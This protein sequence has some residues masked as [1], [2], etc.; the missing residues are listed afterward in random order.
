M[1]AAVTFQTGF[2]NCFKVGLAMVVWVGLSMRADAA[3]EPVTK[4]VELFNGKNLE[5]FYTWLVDT[6][7]TDPRRVFSV[8]NG[9]LRISGDG[10]GYLSTTR[11]YRDYRLELEFKWGTVNTAWGDRLGKARDSGLFLHSAGPDGNSHDGQG[12]FKAAIEC[13][14]FQGATG[15]ILLIRGT[16]EEGRL[17]APRITA[18]VASQPDADGWPVWKPDGEQ[19]IMERWGR[20]NWFGKD[21]DWKDLLDF[22]GPNDIEKARGEWNKLEC[23]CD[24]GRIT[25]KLNGTIVNEA[26]DVFP[27]GGPILLQCEGS[28]I[29]FRNF[30]L[31]PLR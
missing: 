19:R 2:M 17:I 26:F 18:R 4:R 20:L 11:A 13:N 30:E 16:G 12:A 27:S 23:L 15:D 1:H 25:I 9:L 8:T 3:G 29:F 24:G 28:E 14:I 6:K 7:R 5:G 21:R 22:R 31:H 10:L